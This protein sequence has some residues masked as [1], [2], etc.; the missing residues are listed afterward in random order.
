[1]IVSVEIDAHL[2]ISQ[3]H[4]GKLWCADICIAKFTKYPKE[5]KFAIS[6]GRWT[7]DHV[8][9]LWEGASPPDQLGLSSASWTPL[10]R[11][12]TSKISFAMSVIVTKIPLP[13][14]AS[15]FLELYDFLVIV[16]VTHFLS[17]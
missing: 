8:S 16:I 17:F 11:Y 2:R 6:Y 3:I 10:S 5:A 13:L 12:L 9:Q 7:V 14:T 1:M 4:P 15:V